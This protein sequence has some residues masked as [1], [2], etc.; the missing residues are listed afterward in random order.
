VDAVNQPGADRRNLTIRIERTGLKAGLLPGETNR[1]AGPSVEPP[2]GRY[3]DSLVV[4]HPDDYIEFSVAGGCHKRGFM[5]F[6]CR[7]GRQPGRPGIE[8]TRWIGNDFLGKTPQCG[9]A[10][11]NKIVIL[12]ISKMTF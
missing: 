12:H 3:I 4:S 8:V 7:L 10:F 5:T 11:M 2:S 1:S 6:A 9:I